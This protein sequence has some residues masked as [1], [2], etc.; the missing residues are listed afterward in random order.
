MHQ[1]HSWINVPG[2]LAKEVCGIEMLGATTCQVQLSTM[3]VGSIK[4]SEELS[5]D[6][7]KL[8]EENCRV[9]IMLTNR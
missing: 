5:M 7:T 2:T 1:L 4:G 9:S 6:V 3:K 8:K